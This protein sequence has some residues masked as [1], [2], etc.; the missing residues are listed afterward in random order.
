MAPLARHQTSKMF[1]MIFMYL[2]F[3]FYRAITIIH[4]DL[5]DC[6]IIEMFTY[7]RPLIVSNVEIINDALY[8]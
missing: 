1:D 7:L 2:F 5:L 8:F 4:C 6:L 3:S